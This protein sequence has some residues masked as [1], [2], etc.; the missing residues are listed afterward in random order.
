MRQILWTLAVY[1]LVFPAVAVG[2]NKEQGNDKKPAA[3]GPPPPPPG[4]QCWEGRTIL[5]TFC[6]A[7]DS[8]ELT[9]GVREA[10][11][12]TRVPIVH[13]HV[14][15]CRSEDRKYT[16]NDQDAMF[17][18]AQ[19]TAGFILAIRKDAP[20]AQIILMDTAPVR[21]SRCTPPSCFPPIPLTVSFYFP[22]PCPVLMTW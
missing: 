3:K 9:E 20:H 19:R 2:Q 17:C 7:A 21:A 10:I 16:Y 13:R 22:R 4:F 5:F 15:W 1:L 18:A 8:R 14:K 11:L 6:G 12:D